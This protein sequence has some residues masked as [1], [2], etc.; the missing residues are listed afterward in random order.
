M[1]NNC[2]FQ[3]IGGTQNRCI[4]KGCGQIIDSPYPPE[5]IRARCNSSE[6]KAE[7]ELARLQAVAKANMPSIARRVINYGIATAIQKGKGDPLRTYE[8][9]HTILEAHCRNCPTKRFTGSHCSHKKCG[10]PMEEALVFATKGCPDGH[11]PAD[12]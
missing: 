12:A 8:Q 4:H 3:N 2:T 9:V 6:A 5:K 11:F 10:C 7:R 1:S